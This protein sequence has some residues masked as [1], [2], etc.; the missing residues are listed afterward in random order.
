MLVVGMGLIA[1]GSYNLAIFGP[2]AYFALFHRPLGS[3]IGKAEAKAAP[4][5]TPDFSSTA[6]I[7]GSSFNPGDTVTITVSAKSDIYVSAYMEA[8]ITSPANKQIYRSPSTDLTSFRAGQNQSFTFSYG[9][10]SSLPSGT[11]RVSEL[12][13][14]EDGK[15]DYFT[16]ENFARFTLK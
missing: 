7:S 14:S 16:N 6:S 15:A 5:A 1:A 11:Y 2:S 13:N 12:I 10:S 9:L 8:W 3:L 4:I